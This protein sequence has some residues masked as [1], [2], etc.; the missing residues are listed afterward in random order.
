MSVGDLRLEPARGH[1]ISADAGYAWEC[2]IRFSAEP[3]A[4]LRLTLAASVDGEE[5]T[6]VEC[7][8]VA[9]MLIVDRTQSSLSSD[10]DRDLREFQL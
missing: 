8:A 1:E 10:S 9:G 6:V 5:Q 4:W 3:G 7:D 2:R